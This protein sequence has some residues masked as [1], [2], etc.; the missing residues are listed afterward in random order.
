[1]SQNRQQWFHIIL[2]TYGAWL[3]EDKRGFR[4]RHH[5]EHIEGDYQSPPPPGQYERYKNSSQR[6]LQQDVVELTAELRP[7][8]G[9]A[10]R[11]RLELAEGRV[12]TIAVSSQHLHLQV[13]LPDGDARNPIGLAKK[14]AWTLA[15]LQ[16][17][18]GKLLGQR[19][20]IV[21]IKS[22]A[23]QQAVSEYILRHAQQGAWVWSERQDRAS[24]RTQSVGFPRK[25]MTSENA[26]Q[27]LLA[28]LHQYWGYNGFR[29]LQQEAMQAVLAGRDSL[30][31]LPTGG[32][33]SICY[34]APALLMDG[35][36]VVVSPLISLM[37]DQVDSL[38]ECGIA[39]ACVNSSLPARDR[40]RIANEV[41]AGQIKLLYVAPERLS[42][43]R[44][45]DFLQSVK[46][47]FF[48]I[49]EAHCISAWG[50]DFRPEFRLLGQLRERF[51]GVGVHAYT[52]TATDRV[53]SDIAA[54]LQL[55][56]PEILVGSFDRPN[57]IY[58]VERRQGLHQQIEEVMNRHKG[59]S[60]VIY[61]ISRKQVDEL[62]ATLRANGV[63]A[64][65]YHAG[66]SDEE[67]R[68]NQ[69]AFLKEAIDV[70]VATV[71]FGMGIDKSNV[72]FVIHAG[73]PKSIENYQQESGR[74]GRDGLEAECVLFYGPGDFMTWR[75]MQ[76]NLP[77]EALAHA[78]DVLRRME[79]FASSVTCR[80]RSLV[81]YFNQAYEGESC[82][83]C[84]VCLDDLDVVADGQVLAQ[85]IL[86]CVVRVKQQFGAD[87][88]ANVLLG[89]REQRVLDRGHDQL[90]TYGLLRDARKS[91]VR[92]WIEQLAAQGY[93]LRSGEYS[94]L[95][96]TEAGWAVL[97]GQGTPRLLQP[98][99]KSRS[100]KESPSK[101]SRVAADAWEGVH[102][103]L[104]EELRGLRRLLAEAK[105]VPPFV[106]FGDVSLRDMARRRPASMESFHEIHGVGEHKADEYGDA[107]LNIITRYCEQYG[108]EQDVSRSSSTPATPALSLSARAGS[109]SKQQ[110]W[111]LFRQGQSIEDVMATTS[112]ARSTVCEY[113]AEFLAEEGHLTPE[114]WV[115]SG[116]FERIAR[117]AA[118]LE[119]IDRLKPLYDALEGT[120]PYD[121]I[122]L[123]IVCLRNAQTMPGQ[124]RSTL[125]TAVSE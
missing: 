11:E 78:N 82:G 115:P 19:C 74:A 44:M 12:L 31:V 15:K 66:L 32:G 91:D 17:H 103:G 92:N 99:A 111:Q 2:T 67:R 4:T 95:T 62:S 35:L 105:G 55:Q 29:A 97:K 28:V 54:Q 56:S 93:L 75:K 112:R 107:F 34:Q 33:K 118:T 117:A 36:A 81:E 109:E 104:F 94:T 51:P 3:P 122:R 106:V 69:D 50:H 96:V 83:A 21:R 8:V 110:S 16:G 124:D 85:K 120:V 57:L 23:Q 39:A 86:S 45:L 52:A 84:D 64:V 89:S 65:A 37:K 63:R 114:P 113:L 61:C 68:D 116:T 22:R 7:L 9:N 100:A 102:I 10:L 88:V 25:S 27:R 73:A 41:R 72:R 24:H 38:T 48:A 30:V 125:A 46:I 43:D 123:A 58:R 53:R 70:V 13:R 119:T 14:H 80:H 60:G 76:E 87:H 1:M 108:L 6:P 42:N 5:K 40:Q 98:A 79:Q 49:D 20:K 59:E 101:K 47:A 90:S 121:E 18:T 77:Q 26:E 71:A